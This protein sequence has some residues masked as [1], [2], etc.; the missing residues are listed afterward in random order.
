MKKLYCALALSLLSAEFYSTASAQDKGVLKNE[1]N[2]SAICAPIKFDFKAV[3]SALGFGLP[4]TLNFVDTN[5]GWDKNA[6][7]VESFTVDTNRNMRATLDIG[8]E[9]SPQGEVMIL[10]GKQPSDVRLT[11]KVNCEAT[12]GQSDDVPDLDCKPSGAIGQLLGKIND[13]NAQL[14]PAFQSALGGI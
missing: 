2:E 9:P 14:K 3:A 1:L 4:E 7:D 12:V 10:S 13:L 6:H 5:I 8:C 11:E